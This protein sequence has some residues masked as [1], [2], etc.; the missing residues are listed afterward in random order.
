MLLVRYNSWTS[1]FHG[2]QFL[3]L[4]DYIQVANSQYSYD[5]VF[6]ATNLSP[7]HFN[8]SVYYSNVTEND[9]PGVVTQLRAIDDDSNQIV[10]YSLRDAT[11]S[12]FPFQIDSVTGIV[13]ST[14][15][16]DYERQDHYSVVVL[17]SDNGSPPLTGTTVVSVTVINVNDNYPVFSN[18]PTDINVEESA[19]AGYVLCPVTVTTTNPGVGNTVQV[20]VRDDS[21]MFALNAAENAL[22][23]TTYLSSKQGNYLITLLA[24]TGGTPTLNTTFTLTVHVV[25][26]NLFAP[27]FNQ[28]VFVISLNETTSIG[29]KVGQVG[30]SDQDGPSQ[31]LSYSLDYSSFQGTLPFVI[32]LDHGILTNILELYYFPV[33]QYKFKVIVTDNGALPT[34]PLNNT[35]NV[36]VHILDINDLPPQFEQTQFTVHILENTTTETTLLS[37]S[38][39]DQDLGRNLAIS[40]Y[41][42]IQP[43]VSGINNFKLVRT[44][45]SVVLSAINPLVRSKQQTYILNIIAIDAGV[46]PLSSTAT[47]TVIVDSINVD[48]PVFMETSSVVVIPRSTFANT[49]IY[50]LHVD[51]GRPGE[52]IFSC[53]RLLLANTL[54]LYSP[55]NAMKNIFL[56][57]NLLVW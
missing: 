19:P 16:L 37:L 3:N 1:T 40:K 5:I 42:L 22:V 17:A 31:K 44:G 13:R 15:S 48:P 50:T 52:N 9:P 14:A 38:A 41:E 24:Q 33:N 56:L 54:K 21:N 49:I 47:V 46:P 57:P 35:A 28:T 6:N 7:P 10:T 4:F 36:T 51:T 32:D 55:T 23:T 34:G 20:T 11:N 2:V 25:K 18:I 30:A 12:D 39:T 45:D 43:N 8:N 29:T 26:P 27:V 53:V